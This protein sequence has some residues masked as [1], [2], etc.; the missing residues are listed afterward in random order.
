MQLT[1]Q[2]ICRSKMVIYTFSLS[3]L[4]F[5]Q[6]HVIITISYTIRIITHAKSV[7]PIMI[8][9]WSVSPTSI[10]VISSIQ[11][12]HQ[13]SIKFSCLPLTIKMRNKF[14]SI[15][16]MIYTFYNLPLLSSGKSSIQVLD[17]K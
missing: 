17:E 3:L 15:Y 14:N 6:M 5:L 2:P 10:I 8:P 11:K 13:M 12:H 7:I 1:L 9:V 16:S 4:L